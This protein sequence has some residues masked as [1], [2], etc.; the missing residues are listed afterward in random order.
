M[1]RSTYYKRCN[2]RPSKR[3]IE[4]TEISEK[5][6]KIYFKYNKCLGAYK[7]AHILER[8]YGIRVSPARV[9]KLMRELNLPRAMRRKKPR[10]K[11]TE[12]KGVFENR[13]HQEFYPKTPN[14]V[15]C[16]DFT[17][18]RVENHF[19][20]LCV[21]MDLFSRKI[22]G[23]HLSSRHT[24]SLVIEAL[25]KAIKN[26]KINYGLM[27]HSDRGS[28]YTSADFRRLL[29]SMNIVQSF[30]KKGYPYDN[31]C[32]ES[33]FR[34][35]KQEIVNRKTY[36]SDEELYCDIFNYIE[37]FYNDKRPHGT[38]GNCT[39]NEYE[40]CYYRKLG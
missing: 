27:F 33:F 34:Y 23:W 17:Y 19:C 5:I 13:L 1:N 36:H 15:W 14:K 40:E 16:S 35:L 3:A 6:T 29:D 38:L 24:G 4:N 39:P 20:H 26:R 18:I 28:E 2:Y 11:Y 9:N 10:I 12:N 31:A 25:K 21:V 7:I 32:M 8:E 22:I 30:S 37:S